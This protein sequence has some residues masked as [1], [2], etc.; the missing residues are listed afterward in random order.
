MQKFFQTWV[1]YLLNEILCSAIQNLGL[2]SE[3]NPIKD[4][5]KFQADYIGLKILGGAL[6]EFRPSQYTSSIL[7]EVR[8]HQS[9]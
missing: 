7:I 9:I 2:R 6:P 1:A 4:I 5:I 3:G 8:L